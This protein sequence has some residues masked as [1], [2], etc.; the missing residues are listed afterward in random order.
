MTDI[1]ASSFVRQDL[2]PERPAPVKTTG[3]IGFVRTR[4]LNSPTNIL[5]TIVGLLLLWYTVI[6]A[7]RF[8]LV[9]AVW[10]GKDRTACLPE[11]AGHPVG[12]CWPYIQAKLTQL[13]YGFYPEAQRWR[14]DVSFILGAVLLLPLLI[15][16]LPAKG[17]NSGLFF[18]AF[19]VVAFFLLHGGG[20]TGFGVSWVA[21][22]LQ[23]FDESV[24]G[25]GQA[26][27]SLSKTSAIGPLL[28]VIGNV[29]TLLGT[30]IHWVVFPL[31]WLRDQIQA[32]SQ[33]FWIDFVV[34]AVI[35]SAI[36]FALGGG[37]RTGQVIGATDRQGGNAARRPVRFAE[38]F[39]TLYHNIGLNTN[40]VR[41][42]DPNGR[43]QY[44]VEPGINPMREL[45]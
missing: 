43:P 27:V 19:P 30:A 36:L 39:A 13:F 20:I 26:M 24:R 28:W 1:T 37:M 7:I 15:P 31:T 41:I 4:L 32:A 5:L 33:P 2:V 38:V 10:S 12:A 14:V 34:T 18:F 35:A 42:F 40:E 25:A 23:L 8:L 22:L 3:L 21:G 17:L 6:P 29:I 45:I 9:D 11:N 16:R 44:L